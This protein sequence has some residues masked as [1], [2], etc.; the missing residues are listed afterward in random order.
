MSPGQAAMSVE[1]FTAALTIPSPGLTAS[2][3]CQ[4]TTP[5]ARLELWVWVEPSVDGDNQQ[6]ATP[7][8]TVNNAGHRAGRAAWQKLVLPF[9]AEEGAADQS[10]G[11]GM[12][13]SCHR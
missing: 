7:A 1:L 12:P 3:T 10:S 11:D 2:F 13:D 6:P 4:V 8:E 5:D 9:Q